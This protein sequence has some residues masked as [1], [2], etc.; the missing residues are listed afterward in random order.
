MATDWTEFRLGQLVRL[1][2]GQSPSGF[3]FGVAG[4]PYFKVDQLG[5]ATKYLGRRSTPYLS[6]ALPSVPEGSVLIAKRGGAIALNR[7]RILAEPGFMDTNVMALTP[8]E[9]IESEFLYYWL[10]YR[11]LWDIADV[12]SVPQINN[13]H[14]NPMRIALPP[15]AEQRSIAAVLADVDDLIE[16]LEQL[17]AKKEAITLGLMQQLLSGKTRLPGF[18]G[19]WAT[20]A[21]GEIAHVTMGQSPPSGSYNADGHGV[22]LIQGNADIR[23]RRTIGRIWTTAPT[24]TCEAGDLLL[25]V[26]APV[27][28]TAIASHT[29]CLGRGVCS[30]STTASSRYLFHALVHAERRWAASEQGSTFT[31][32]NSAQ[33]RGFTISL[34][35]KPAEQKA[36]AAVLDDAESELRVLYSRLVKT[37]AIKQGMMQQLLTGRTRLQVAEVAA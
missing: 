22:P 3:R 19:P 17:I 11:R 24:K 18:D 2:S 12:T 15:L 30:L 32:V 29:S 26:R 9:A 5:K 21:L 28:F 16:T 37:R 27:G 1:T 6:D 33:V 14:I 25:T 7:V 20:R 35:E 10:A 4:K 8:T 34:P 31:A 36:I 13:K 23:D